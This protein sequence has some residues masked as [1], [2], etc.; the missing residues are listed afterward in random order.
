MSETQKAQIIVK[1]YDY[2]GKSLSE[3]VLSMWIA[4]LSDI[5]AADLN[6]ALTK[7]IQ[8]PDSGQFLPKVADIRKMLGGTTQDGALIAWTKVEQAIRR[9][10]IYTSVV[11]DDPLI[12]AV[13][14]DMGGWIKLCNTESDE[15]LAFISNEFR[16]RYQG[17]RRNQQAPAHQPVMIGLAEAQNAKGGFQI[18]P[19]K[20]L[21]DP[22]KAQIVMDSGRDDAAAL[23]VTDAASLSARALLQSTDRAP[24]I[25]YSDDIEF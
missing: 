3:G 11:F 22:T 16:Q 2:Y 15:K 21:G 1:T 12:H 5:S 18:Q 6:E 7:H 14:V 4:G 24:K 13:L 19:P 25:N 23:R 9:V 8:N 20:L 17:Y 10:G